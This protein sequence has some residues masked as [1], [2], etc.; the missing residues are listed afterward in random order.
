MSC[1]SK[2]SKRSL[3]CKELQPFDFAL[4]DY[5]VDCI[6]YNQFCVIIFH[7][8]SIKLRLYA[9]DLMYNVT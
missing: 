4:H 1:K 7:H 3:K 5:A 6:I 9:T 8:F 2:D